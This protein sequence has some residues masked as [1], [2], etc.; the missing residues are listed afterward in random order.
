MLPTELRLS[1]N[2][3]GSGGRADSARDLVNSTPT[4]LG[5]WFTTST[6]GG[7]PAQDTW[8]HMKIVAAGSSF[9]CYWDGFELTTTPIEDTTL[10]SGWVGV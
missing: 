2:R 1:L 5:T 9:R 10:P 4:T 6:P 3:S 8:H 7:L